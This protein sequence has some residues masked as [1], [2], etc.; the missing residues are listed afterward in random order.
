M[1][2]IHSFKEFTSTTI[3]CCMPVLTS[4]LHS[5]SII[6]SIEIAM[7]TWVNRFALHLTILRITS[8]KKLHNFKIWQ[9]RSSQVSW[10]CFSNISLSLQVRLL[11]CIIPAC[12]PYHPMQKSCTIIKRLDFIASALLHSRLLTSRLKSRFRTTSTRD[13]SCNVS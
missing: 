1:F 7:V 10:S 2:H 8:Q 3:P 6:I 5:G 12:S 13:G 9:L 11:S 4:W